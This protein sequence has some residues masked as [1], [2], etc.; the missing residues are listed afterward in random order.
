MI[1]TVGV[2]PRD[3]RN[4]NRFGEIFEIKSKIVTKYKTKEIREIYEFC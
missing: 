4:E 3:K 1:V 2:N